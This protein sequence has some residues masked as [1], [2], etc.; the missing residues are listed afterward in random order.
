ME[1]CGNA[2]SINTW[3]T[4]VYGP[5][6][7]NFGAGSGY[8]CSGRYIFIRKDASHRYF[9]LSVRGNILEPLSTNLYPDSTAVAGD[10]VWVMNLPDSDVQ[11]L[12]SLQNTGVNVHRLMLI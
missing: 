6:A 9:K 1:A 2:E 8:D 7:E 3:Q 4:V 10:K 11:W 12:Y 5:L